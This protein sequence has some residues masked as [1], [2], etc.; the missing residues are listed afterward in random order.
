MGDQ[1]KWKVFL[2]KK[3]QFLILVLSLEF[4]KRKNSHFISVANG[5]AIL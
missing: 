3:V 5:C 2:L 1:P 4:L